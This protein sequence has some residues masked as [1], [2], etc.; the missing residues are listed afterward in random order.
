M[1]AECAVLCIKYM[2]NVI[3]DN[4]QEIFYR[5]AGPEISSHE[6]ISSGAMYQI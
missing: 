5:T 3:I 6:N 4:H 2:I 1:L